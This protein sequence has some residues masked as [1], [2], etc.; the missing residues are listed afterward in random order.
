MIKIYS[1]LHNLTP[2]DFGFASVFSIAQQIPECRL[3]YEWFLDTKDAE[4][5]GL[6]L[7]RAANEAGVAFSWQ[8]ISTEVYAKP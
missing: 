3:G 1:V 5:K 6:A 8:L 4:A 2:S 7:A